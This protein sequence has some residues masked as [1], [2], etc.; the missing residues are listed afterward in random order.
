MPEPP[1]K[2]LLTLEDGGVLLQ[3]ARKGES[4]ARD[5]L[6]DAA[7]NYL[8][9]VAHN[10]IDSDLRGRLSES[11][12]VQET[13]VAAVASFADFRGASTVQFAAWLRKAF[14]NNL[15]NQYRHYRSTEKRDSTRELP[16]AA[17]PQLEKSLK[18]NGESP[19]EIAILRE[20]KLLVTRAVDSL[21]GDYRQVIELRHGENLSFVEIGER[22]DR[23]PDAVRMTWYRAVQTLSKML[24]KE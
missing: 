22:M 1:P 2:T 18:G 17:R 24:A 4:S 19:P 6:F 7:R 10:T 13:M 12:V 8:R 11:D 5:Q 20:E 21:T 9:I 15:L 3:R 23:S 14:V 16:I